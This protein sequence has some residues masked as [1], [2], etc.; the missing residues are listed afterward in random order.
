M[1][2]SDN[3]TDRWTAV[4]ITKNKNE[5]YGF[6]LIIGDDISG[7]MIHQGRGEYDDDSK[8]NTKNTK[9]KKVDSKW[10]RQLKNKTNNLSG[11]N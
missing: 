5:E 2:S 10:T 4:A 7:Y 8:S 3:N 9:H 1:P 6:R 11:E